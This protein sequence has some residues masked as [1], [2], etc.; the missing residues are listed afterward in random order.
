MVS[1]RSGYCSLLCI[2]VADI[3]KFQFLDFSKVFEAETW[4]MYVIDHSRPR[5]HGFD[6][7][8][9]G[10]CNL[11][12]TTV[13]DIEKFHFLTFF[14]ELEAETPTVVILKWLCFRFVL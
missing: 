11:L 2:T 13:A 8:W 6:S 5:Q 12:S 1:T 10:Y 9:S 3:E 7:T 14:K 4:V